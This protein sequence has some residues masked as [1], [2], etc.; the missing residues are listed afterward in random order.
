M[1]NQIRQNYKVLLIALLAVAII[2]C[3]GMKSMGVGKRPF[4]PYVQHVADVEAT[5]EQKVR[6][7]KMREMDPEIFDLVHSRLVE[8][9]TSEKS[10]VAL[11]LAYMKDAIKVNRT[12]LVEVL[13]Y[14]K[15]E[16]NEHLRMDLK[17]MG[18]P[19]DNDLFKELK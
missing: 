16:A 18:W 8:Y 6:I 17:K 13:N 10:R 14:S 2:G 11:E 3:N 19:E 7:L 15:E 5:A 1:L 4:L 12:Q 9:K